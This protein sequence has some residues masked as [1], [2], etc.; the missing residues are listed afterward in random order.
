MQKN[1]KIYK[2]YI[3]NIFKIFKKFASSYLAGKINMNMKKYLSF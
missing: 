3:D 1:S 2:K